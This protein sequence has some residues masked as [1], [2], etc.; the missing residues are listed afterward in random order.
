MP[1]NQN[2]RRNGNE[3]PD[4]SRDQAHYA[5]RSLIA[6]E[7]DGPVLKH[8][9]RRGRNQHRD[10][11]RAF[12]QQPGKRRYRLVPGQVQMRP[13][14]NLEDADEHKPK[15]SERQDGPAR[16][17]SVR[18]QKYPVPGNSWTRQTSGCE[19]R[20]ARLGVRLGGRL[21]RR[22]RGAF[23]V[24]VQALSKACPT[25]KIVASSKCLPRICIPMGSPSRDFPHGTDTPQIPARLAVT[26]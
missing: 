13:N 10:K 6:I 7:Q 22:R 9:H 17:Q 21:R 24:F 4:D 23:A 8:R 25:R 3:S 5:R 20:C 2:D 15:A 14:Q 19:R 18:S 12:Q 11:L 1:Q 26:V 16:T